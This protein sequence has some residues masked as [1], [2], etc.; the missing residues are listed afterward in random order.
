MGNV[1]AA[2][3][4]TD[5]GGTN[6]PASQVATASQSH[7]GPFPAPGERWSVTLCANSWTA[8]DGANGTARRWKRSGPSTE[9]AA[10]QP[11]AAVYEAWFG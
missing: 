5:R 8:F 1:P 7:A 11:V 4:G 3:Q 10:F 2:S 9:P 6:W